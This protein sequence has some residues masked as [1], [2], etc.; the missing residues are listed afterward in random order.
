MVYD[1]AHITRDVRVALDENR[2]SEPLLTEED[3]DTLSLEEI[4]RGKIEAAARIVTAQAPRQL[5]DGG[6]PLGDAVFWRE[7][8][9]GWTLLP[10]DFMRLLIFKMCDWERPVYEAI[11]EEDAR[12]G[13][14]YSRYG[15][16][17]GN[18]QKPVVAIVRR[19]VGLV[20][21]FFSCRSR[22]AHVEQGLYLPLP[23]LDR[24]D[25]IEIPPRLYSS[26]VY[27]AAALVALSIGERE[28]AAGLSETSKQLLI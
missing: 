24:G 11:T 1:I 22:E 27:E 23:R 3:V 8:G 13:M 4:V 6:R 2:R 10:D 16:L 18:P 19:S 7:N 21:E 9:A 12:Y 25:G 28:M 26:V 14:Q 15:G 5:L 17:R 20:L